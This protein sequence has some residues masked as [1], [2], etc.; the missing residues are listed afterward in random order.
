MGS[1]ARQSGAAKRAEGVSDAIAAVVAR[2]PLAAHAKGR[3]RFFLSL[4]DMVAAVA[5]SF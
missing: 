5:N 3:N 2:A 4:R 1:L